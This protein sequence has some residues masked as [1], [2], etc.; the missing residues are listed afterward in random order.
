MVIFAISSQLLHRASLQERAGISGQP[1]ERRI[2][3]SEAR[4]ALDHNPASEMTKE[5]L[6]PLPGF[7]KLIAPTISGAHFKHYSP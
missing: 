4:L 7:G 5:I 1:S 6:P 2:F 3:C